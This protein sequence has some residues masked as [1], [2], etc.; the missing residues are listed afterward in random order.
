MWLRN[1]WLGVVGVA[2]SVVSLALAAYF[3][4]ASQEHRAPVFALVPQRTE[5]FT[6]SRASEAPIR[7]TLAD[8]RPVKKDLT[9]VRWFFWNAGR[10]P[11][12]SGDVLE[13]L[14]VTLGDPAGRIVDF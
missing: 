12:R 13:P 7:V 14:R 8:G 11:I 6:A 2:V 4:G 3:Y 5:I 10:K 1:N 9:A